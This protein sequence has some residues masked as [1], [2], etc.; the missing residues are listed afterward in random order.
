[1]PLLTFITDEALYEEIVKY[2]DKTLKDF[3][4]EAEKALD[5]SINFQVESTLEQK[6]NKVMQHLEKYKIGPR[7]LLLLT[8]F[9]FPK[10][11]RGKLWRDTQKAIIKNR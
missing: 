11:K 9:S 5:K 6:A 7:L 2:M 1:M 3:V 8:V 10:D 4:V